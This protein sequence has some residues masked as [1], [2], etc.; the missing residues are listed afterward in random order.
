M[1]L[2]K[3]VPWIVG[4][5]VLAA[6]FFFG[7]I[8]FGG[9]ASSTGSVKGSVHDI[10]TQAAIGNVAIDVEVPQSPDAYPDKVVKS[11]RTDSKG[12][13]SIEGLASGKYGL[14]FRKLGY[15]VSI[16]YVQICSDATLIFDATLQSLQSTI[17][18]DPILNA[19]T[20]LAGGRTLHK[21]PD[22]KP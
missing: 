20:Y 17:A 13:F 19:P 12:F 4:L 15:R 3:F 10:D 2:R 16:N 1:S 5:I 21:C 9:P 6:S 22:H 18:H 11:I 14:K 8:S 7:S